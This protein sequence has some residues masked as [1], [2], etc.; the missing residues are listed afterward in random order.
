[1]SKL[2]TLPTEV[3]CM[4]GSHMRGDDLGSMAQASKRFWKL[5]SPQRYNKIR[6]SGTVPQLAE[7][8][9]LLLDENPAAMDLIRS[10]TK[11]VSIRVRYYYDS[12]TIVFAQAEIALIRNFLRSVPRL[13]D[14][15]FHVTIFRHE[16]ILA[17]N[18]ALRK[19]SNWS[20]PRCLTFPD[21]PAE[22]T[23]NAI[24]RRFAPGI[25]EAVQLPKGFNRKHF[26]S[27]K[28]PPQGRALKALH[29][30]RTAIQQY[31][32]NVIPSLDHEFLQ[33]VNSHFPQLETLIFHED[34]HIV[35][36]YSDSYEWPWGLT[37]FID[38]LELDRCVEALIS[39]LNRMPNLRRFAF[40]LWLMRLHKSLVQHGWTGLIMLFRAYTAAEV[41]EFYLLYVEM[42]LDRV[43]TL[44]ELCISSGHPVFYR[45]TRQDGQ[46]L[47]RRESREN[48]GEE[49]RFPPL[50]LDLP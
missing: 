17:F 5:F 6:F 29:I 28:K 48:P 12:E 37:W 8:I 45:G 42:I 1:M 4:I 39:A 32:R 19:V 22:S 3:V 38:A 44:E 2:A 31:V 46:V 41:V 18:K 47:V 50:L 25:I 49:D 34:T 36:G 20:T 40:M 43:P 26:T 16:N 7:S 15:R 13:H 23:F 21:Y 14:L 30:D 10:F 11:F 24:V 33:E 35:G 27:L 9:R